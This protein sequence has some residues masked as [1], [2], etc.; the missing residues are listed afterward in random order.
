MKNIMGI[1]NKHTVDELPEIKCYVCEINRLRNLVERLQ[2]ERNIDEHLLY[3]KIN[4][5]KR[6]KGEI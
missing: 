6:L 2:A 1:C 4:E 5:I 3:D